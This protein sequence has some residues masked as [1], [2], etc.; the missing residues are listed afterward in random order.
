VPII[1]WLHLEQFCFVYMHFHVWIGNFLN[2]Y[3]MVILMANNGSNTFHY[4]N[5]IVGCH[6]SEFWSFI[7]FQMEIYLVYKVH[8]I[9]SWNTH[10]KQSNKS[11]ISGHW[12]LKWEGVVFGFIFHKYDH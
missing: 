6:L 5:L 1:Y 8:A 3:S 12:L 7:P 11:F 4:L 9:T 10:F 2:E